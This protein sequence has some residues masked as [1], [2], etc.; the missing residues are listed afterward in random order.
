MD[1]GQLFPRVGFVVTNLNLP[2]EGVTHFY[3]GRG[4]AEQWIREGKYALDWTRLSSKMVRC[5][6]P[7]SSTWGIPVK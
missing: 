4:T 7:G 3:N 1:Q 6:D 5:L 2:P